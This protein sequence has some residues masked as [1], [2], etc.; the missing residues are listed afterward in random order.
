MFWLTY[1]RRLNLILL[2]SSFVLVMLELGASALVEMMQMWKHLTSP[3]QTELG[4]D[5]KREFTLLATDLLYTSEREST[6]TQFTSH[7]GEASTSFGF[8]GNGSPGGVSMRSNS[9]WKIEQSYSASC[10]A[11]RGY[12][13]SKAES[14]VHRMGFVQWALTSSEG[15]TMDVWQTTLLGGIILLPRSWSKQHALRHVRESQHLWHRRRTLK[16]ST[17][18]GW[19]QTPANRLPRT[20]DLDAWQTPSLS[21]KYEISCLPSVLMLSQH[22]SLATPCVSLVHRHLLD[23]PYLFALELE[24]LLR[25]LGFGLGL[26][27][28]MCKSDVAVLWQQA[29]TYGLP[30]L[31]L[32]V[33]GTAPA[34]P[35]NTTVGLSTDLGGD[36]LTRLGF[37]FGF[38]GSSRVMRGKLDFWSSSSLPA[39][40]IQASARM[41]SMH[42]RVMRMMCG[43]DGGG[44][45]TAEGR[46]CGGCERGLM[47]W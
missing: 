47:E 31:V 7:G 18:R 37:G 40:T 19:V 39:T 25:R 8:S 22:G 14:A 1:I 30:F 5:D 36:L 42:G 2:S 24:F 4:R 38:S 46:V 17:H 29:L 11:V 23:R 12:S 20:M 3:A 41:M 26:K 10:V 21:Q 6:P 9:T 15:A 33:L 28:G 35:A 13:A 16:R 45:R 43:C 27:A 32:G 44:A 34:L